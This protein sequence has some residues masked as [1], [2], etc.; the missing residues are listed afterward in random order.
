[1][2]SCGGCGP[3]SPH[4]SYAYDCS[5]FLTFVGYS[6]ASSDSSP[7]LCCKFRG[8]V[9][10]CQHDS[11]P[12]PSYNF[13]GF[14]HDLSPGLSCSCHSFVL[15]FQHGSSLKL[16]DYPPSFCQLFSDCLPHS[17]T[18]RILHMF[19]LLLSLCVHTF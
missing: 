3:P 2:H 12:D 13:C 1:M 16:L 5:C 6:Q 10:Q 4:S 15:H 19:T 14:M 11:F 9:L 7:S 18:P 8:F 17:T